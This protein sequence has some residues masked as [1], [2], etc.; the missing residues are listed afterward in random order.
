MAIERTF[1]CHP[2]ALVEFFERD[3]MPIMKD[4]QRT[5]LN[6]TPFAH[7]LSMPPANI[8]ACLLTKLLDAFD[9]DKNVF[10]ICGEAVPFTVQDVGV[11]LGLQIVGSAINLHPNDKRVRLSDCHTR[12]H[13]DYFGTEKKVT[14]KLLQDVLKRLACAEGCQKSDDFV[15]LMVLYI[16]STVLFPRSNKLVTTSLIPYL[17]KIEDLKDLW[18]FNW[19]GL[20]HQEMIVLLVSARKDSTQNIGGC[21]LAVLISFLE[22]CHVKKYH[23][24]DG[25][26][27]RYHNWN[28]CHM[29]LTKEKVEKEIFDK[30]IKG[31][32]RKKELPLTSHESRHLEK[33]C[34]PELVIVNS[35]DPVMEKIRG[36]GKR[37]RRSAN[38]E[39][40]VEDGGVSLQEEDMCADHPIA[41]RRER[42][43]RKEPERLS[44]SWQEPIKKKAREETQ[45]KKCTRSPACDSSFPKRT[46]RVS[47]CIT[48]SR[49]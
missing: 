28:L 3:I 6:E 41:V 2:K 27:P 5:K 14:R 8:S 12:F 19:A 38:E 7:L 37:K 43:A 20:V 42:R 49:S 11:A 18:K 13:E 21:T 10:M 17:T 26:W 48:P 29:S 9:H 32:I 4:V 33:G 23:I 1:T 34:R 46:R 47:A 35:P 22:R 16:F 30:I 39:E 45:Q 15:I 31:Q 36:K 24:G 44:L 40:R 25:S